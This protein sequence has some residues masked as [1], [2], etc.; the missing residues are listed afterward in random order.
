[1]VNLFPK[2]K[3]FYTLFEEQAKK[4]KQGAEILDKV[5]AN[6]QNIQD[7]AQE[8]KKLES[9][10]DAVGHNVVG[11][12]RKSFITPLEGEDIDLL[13]QKLDD[14]MDFMEM[15]VNR[16]AIYKVSLPLP[17]EITKF[18]KVLREIIEEIEKGV[19]E[20]RNVRKH[21][22][23]LH[24]RCERINELEN[25]TDEIH[26]TALKEL[27]RVE[28]PSPTQILEII[29]LKE[30]YAAFEDAADVA[31]DVGNIFESILIKHR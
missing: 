17:K 14:I 27:M 26:R 13:R 21:Q 4:L 11:H 19:I 18:I 5:L 24:Q 29:K 2:D 3:I 1:M 23:K 6:P 20:M 8:M 9:Q 22:E 25:I 30:I 31:E 12:L 16:L 15:A 10:A 28:N 7:Y